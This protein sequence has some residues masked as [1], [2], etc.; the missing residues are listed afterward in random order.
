MPNT[1]WFGREKRIFVHTLLWTKFRGG[2]EDCKQP[3]P[4]N[5]IKMELSGEIA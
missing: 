5:T 3:K 4:G 1:I 2:G